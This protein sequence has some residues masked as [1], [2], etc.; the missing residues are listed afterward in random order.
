MTCCLLQKKKF[1]ATQPGISFTGSV[2]QP[3]KFRVMIIDSEMTEADG[4]RVRTMHTGRI[5]IGAGKVI[6][7]KC[8]ESFAGNAVLVIVQISKSFSANPLHTCLIERGGK[9]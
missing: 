6:P 3:G 8:S 5:R 7:M 4:L 9:H 1:L 2:R